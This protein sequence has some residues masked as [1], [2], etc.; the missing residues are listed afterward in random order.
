M[1]CS[2]RQEPRVREALVLTSAA[3]AARRP[4]G[5]DLPG[6][7]KHVELNSPCDHVRGALCDAFN[8]VLFPVCISPMID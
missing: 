7:Q 3:G 6:S 5:L 1:I 8:G 4:S 2:T